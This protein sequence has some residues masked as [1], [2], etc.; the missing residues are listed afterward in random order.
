MY[1][2]SWCLSG[3][4]SDELKHWHVGLTA[5]KLSIPLIFILNTPSYTQIFVSLLLYL[6]WGRKSKEKYQ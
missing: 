4:C 5:C 1:I 2:F 3:E 6:G